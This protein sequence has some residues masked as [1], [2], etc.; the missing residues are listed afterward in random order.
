MTTLDRTP[1]GVL[2]VGQGGRAYHPVAGGFAACSPL[3][4]IPA[5]VPIDQVSGVRWCERRGCRPHWQ[6]E[7]RPVATV[8]GDDVEYVCPACL[9]ERA[10]AGRPCPS[11]GSGYAAVPAAAVA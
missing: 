1:G 5:P 3:L 11:C 9:V 6:R 4:P 2:L 10:A 8:A 7:R